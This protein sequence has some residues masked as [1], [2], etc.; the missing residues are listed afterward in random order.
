[1]EGSGSGFR[2]RKAQKHTYPDPQYWLVPV[3]GPLSLLTRRLLLLVYS[4]VLFSSVSDLDQYRIR[5][6]LV[7]LDPVQ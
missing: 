2:T 6:N 5:V 4:C 1:M 7:L 3:P